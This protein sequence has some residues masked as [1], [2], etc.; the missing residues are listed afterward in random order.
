MRSPLSR[1]HPPAAL[2]SVAPDDW[3]L[4]LVGPSGAA[5]RARAAFADAV[6][7]D[8]SALIVADGGLDCDVVARAIHD[9]SRPGTPFVVIDCTATDAAAIERDLFGTRRRAVAHAD[10]DIVTPTSALLRVG[11]GTLYLN[12]VVELPAAAQRR[13]ARILRDA[14]VGTARRRV[15]LRGRIVG[16]APASVTA[17]VGD[18][19]FRSDLFR[20][21]S[22]TC[23][24]IPGLRERREDV[25][26]LAARVA[27][28]LRK[29][30]P[31]A[32]TQAALTVLSAA[33]WPGN[34]DELRAVLDRVLRA[35]PPGAVRQ[36]DVLAHLPIDSAFTGV[37]PQSSLREARRQFERQYIASVLERNDWSMS[38]AARALGIERANLY[39]KTRQLGI[40]RRDGAPVAS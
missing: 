34:L 22:Q 8:A 19:H 40:V 13:L 26:D 30:A 37:A 16:S 21:I 25:P 6:R 17:E 2:R 15:R 7:T 33:A 23:I 32:F 36:E 5:G 20:R 35:A 14:E 39:R 24:A 9:R 4:P 31:Q 3:P 27:A 29:G 28:G 38:D 10:V 12:H 11:R 18:G 1:S